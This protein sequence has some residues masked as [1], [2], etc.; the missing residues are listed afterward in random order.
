MTETELICD[1]C[2]AAPPGEGAV[3][4]PADSFA[5]AVAGEIVWASN[6]AWLACADCQPIVEHCMWDALAARRALFDRRVT[7]V[8]R[9]TWDA[10]AAN[11]H[12]DVDPIPVDDP[13]A[14]ALLHPVPFD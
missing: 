6:G 12:L 4:Y 14:E 2:G 10:F 1:F 8:M 9:M 5:I 7:G 3:L 11:R 13:A